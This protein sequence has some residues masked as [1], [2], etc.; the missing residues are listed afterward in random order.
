MKKVLL[1][2]TNTEKA[3][4]PIV[5]AGLCYLATSIA[6]KFSVRIYDGT[7]DGGKHLKKVILEFN[8]DFIGVTVRNIDDVVMKSCNYYMQDILDRF[9]N[10][11]HD[12]TRTP[13]I[14]GGNGFS[15]FPR[16][17]MTMFNVDYGIIGEGEE[18]FLQLLRALING[19]D[20]TT[21]P[22]VICRTMGRF[23]YGKSVSYNKLRENAIPKIDRLIHFTPYREQSSYPIQTKRGCAFQCLY[24][25]YPKLEGTEY[26]L[27][28]PESIVQE[29]AAVKKRLGDVMIEFV[30]ST[31]NIPV[32][33]A[34]TIC[35]EIL[36]QKL[37][38]RIRTMGINPA[39]VT[40]NLI[41][42]MKDAGF[43]QID[44]TP[45]TASARMLESLQKG[46][47]LDKLRQCADLIRKHDLPTMWFFIFGSPGETEDT[48][49]ET[50]AF[51]DQFISENDLVHIT[52][53]IRIYP[54]TDL[55]NLA[56]K[57]GVISHDDSLFEPTFYISPTI[58]RTVLS[59]ILKEEIHNR[60]NVVHAMNSTP[61]PKVLKKALDIRKRQEVTEPLFRT[62]LKVN[63]LPRA[64]NK[65]KVGPV[66]ILLINPP[67]SPHNS[68]LQ[69]APKE[70]KR[71][72]H[73]KLI[74][75]PLG[76]LTIAAAVKEHNVSLLEMKGEYDLHPD[77]PDIETLTLQWLEMSNPQIVGITFI[78]SEFD[79]GIRIFRAVKK[80]NPNIITV[81]GGLH[82]TLC[83][84]EFCD[85]S[86]DI[87]AP[88]QSEYVFKEIVRIVQKNDDLGKV[89]GILINKG[90]IL[91]RKPSPSEEYDYAGCDFIVPDRSLI[92]RWIST[93]KVGNATDPSTY[94][95]TSL[96]CPYRCT[97]CSI[98]PQLNGK[99]MQRSIESII[100]ELKSI[101]DYP[102][103]RFAD[104]NTV[105][106]P[107]F[108]E[109]LFQRIE[110]EHINKV[111]I[112][113][114]RFDTV[115]KY[116]SLIEKMAKAGLK[117]V[118][119]GFESFRQEELEQYNK[120]A[121]A[122]Q[123]EEAI[124]IFDANGIMVRGNYV[125]PPDY[126]EDDFNALSDYA[127]SHK[128]VY[129]GYTILTPMPGTRLFKK[130]APDIVD[131]DLAKYNFFN[132]VMKTK[133][134][135]EEYYRSVGKLWMIKRGV[136]VI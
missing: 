40:Q 51:I 78:A 95:Y 92:K 4:Y 82:T 123:I 8:P 103:V 17:I 35:R 52:E 76:L 39:G 91:K 61:E 57:E 60:I 131:R 111:Y 75:P 65:K 54:G 89:G 120:S 3:P 47:D 42:L 29:M 113:D 72:I 2:N 130:L 53:G 14:L 71:F 129:A 67:R 128:V 116:P 133:M 62:L 104:A 9:I 46:F 135:L 10:P 44:C 106:D 7:F 112:M 69:Y 127:A 94:L 118:I 38:L 99:F 126:T 18:S 13:V 102:I 79:Y 109:K 110:E 1:V 74:G 68:I 85:G 33:H 6:Q 32:K 119:C 84:N 23:T 86:V 114:I 59:K 80:F 105:V 25:T 64:A 93:Y 24:C 49:R 16:Q 124:K 66:D 41:T 108:I 27:R 121:S 115:V 90:G 100:T 22:G 70:A 63:R 30:D 136:D 73:K 5:P 12:T 81:A 87:V 134:P 19:Q 28:S 48:I 43:V 96:G 125:I 26:R 101:D 50:F 83:P 107:H 77:S 36:K 15:I 97:F 132:C 122:S 31:F 37:S 55:Y 11:I 56:I 88:G 45:D 58:E 34:E 117:V 98:W 21:V 20:P